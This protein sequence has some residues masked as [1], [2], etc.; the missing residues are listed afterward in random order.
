MPR[1]RILIEGSN[2]ELPRD[3]AHVQ[4]E[5]VRG[6]FVSRIVNAPSPEEAAARA[7]TVIAFDWSGGQFSHLKLCPNLAVAEVR[8]AGLWEWLRAKN[9]G[10]V[11][12]PG[13]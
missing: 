5:V 13:N 2:I 7:T 12:H 1:F 3:A 6:F 10:Y 11:F 8:P 9:T 4:S